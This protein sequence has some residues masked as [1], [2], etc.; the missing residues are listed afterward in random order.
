YLKSSIGA[1][2]FFCFFS[3]RRRHTRSKRDWFRRVLFR[4]QAPSEIFRR[5]QLNRNKEL[6]HVIERVFSISDSI[7]KESYKRRKTKLKIRRSEERRVGKEYRYR[8]KEYN[9]KKT[10]KKSKK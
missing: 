7:S 1:M 8:R 9:E 4:S 5:G 10:Q 6:K 3:S 2:F